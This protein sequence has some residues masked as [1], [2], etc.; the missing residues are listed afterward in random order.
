MRLHTVADG[1]KVALPIMFAYCG[2]GF[3]SGIIC[4]QLGLSLLET[5]LVCL[6]VF[7]GLRAIH[8]REYLHAG[9]VD[10]GVADHPH[11]RPLF[12]L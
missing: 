9:V 5:I 7:S 2:L 10:S 1:V 12:S 6:L 8:S 3:A 11:Q 4:Q